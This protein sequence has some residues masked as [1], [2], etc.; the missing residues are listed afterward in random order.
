MTVVFLVA[1]CAVPI[2]HE[3]AVTKEVTS[4][5]N[6]FTKVHTYWGPS[7]DRKGMLDRGYWA[8]YLQASRHE[9]SS[10]FNFYFF[11]RDRYDGEARF[12]NSAYDING[13]SLLITHE[14]IKIFGCSSRYSCS[15]WEDVSIPMSLEYLRQHEIK[16][17]KLQLR[18][19]GGTTIVELP[20]IYIRGFLAA[21]PELQQP[22]PTRR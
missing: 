2:K 8:T 10:H 13:N 15:Y 5:F 4:G 20:G 6:E 17:I 3:R 12:Y 1:G 9:R 14:D 19:K 11:I 16:G 21:L 7:I 22:K 18:G